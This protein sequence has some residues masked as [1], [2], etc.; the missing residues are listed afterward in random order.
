MNIIIVYN[1]TNIIS[2]MSEGE[3][4]MSCKFC[5]VGNWRPPEQTWVN[6]F[7]GH[8]FA[9]HFECEKIFVGH[10]FAQYFECLSLFVKHCYSLVSRDFKGTLGPL[11]L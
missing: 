1:M 7:P 8:Q 9:L 2:C 5:T 10:N 3:A 4:K 11:R 6:N